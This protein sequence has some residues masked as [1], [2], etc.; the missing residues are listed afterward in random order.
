MSDRT[1]N[2]ARVDR[3]LNQIIQS[4]F[5][6]VKP[7]YVTEEESR[8]LGVEPE[9][10]L[11]HGSAHRLK[12][13]RSD[14]LDVTYALATV[15]QDGRIEVESSVNNKSDGFDYD[16]FMRRLRDYYWRS[17]I[18]KP[19]TRPNFDR[20]TYND[21]M[22]FEPHMGDS[23]TL[24]A[25]KDKADIIRLRFPLRARHLGLLMDHEDLLADL[26]ENYCLNPLKRIFAESYHSGN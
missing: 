3:I 26:I 4:W 23:V 25:R 19:W 9:I 20:F 5:D 12:F 7:N 21:L 15:E 24:E 11:F 14:E 6:R 16:A 13:A 17:R 10:K 1:G 22:P 2:L 8:Q 18:E